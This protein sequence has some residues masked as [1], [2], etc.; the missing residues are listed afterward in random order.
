MTTEKPGLRERKKEETRRTLSDVACRLAMEKG[1]SQVRVEDIAAA[2]NV[3]MRTF[4]NY[5][6]SKEAAIVG[7][8]YQRSERIA[9]T[10]ASRPSGE[11]LQDSIRAAVLDGFA[12]TTDRQWYARI[13]L[14]RDDPALFGA[15][16]KVEIE[17][18]REL[19]KVISERTHKDVKLDLYPDLLAA[20]LMAAIRTA[21]FHWVSAPPG[22]ETLNGMLEQAIGQLRFE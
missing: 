15:T 12:E 7:N 19:A 14:L 5:F 2:A 20:L 4:N 8:A 16:R 22:G 11:P 21:V 9:A 3:S 1:A 13:V 18:E 6:A 17:I 10:L